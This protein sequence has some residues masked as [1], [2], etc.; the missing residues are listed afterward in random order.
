MK[1]GLRISYPINESLIKGAL[2][3]RVQWPSQIKKIVWDS[4]MGGTD[5]YVV[6]VSSEG[7]KVNVHREDMESGLMTR[8]V[9]YSIKTPMDFQSLH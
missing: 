9:L 4:N 5:R 6:C 2:L 1:W 8:G 7:I 3:K